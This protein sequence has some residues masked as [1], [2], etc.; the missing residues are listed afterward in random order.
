MS[1]HLQCAAA[2]FVPVALSDAYAVVVA[3]QAT[4]SHRWQI[5]FRP[6]FTHD[7]AVQVEAHLEEVTGIVRE[8]ETALSAAADRVQASDAERDAAVEAAASA[9]AKLADAETAT[10]AAQAD[11]VLSLIHI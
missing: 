3:I 1:T 4:R 8:M 7:R 6:C 5:R 11:L 2:R 10:A 9:A